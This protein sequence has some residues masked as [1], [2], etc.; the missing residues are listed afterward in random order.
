VKGAVMSTNIVSTA[1]HWN[2]I[3]TLVS[4]FIFLFE[5]VLPVRKAGLKN[6]SILGMK[7]I[8][9]PVLWSMSTLLGVIVGLLPEIVALSAHC[10]PGY[11]T[12]NW[13]H[14][15][16]YIILPVALF[17]LM[18]WVVYSQEKNPEITDPNMMMAVD[19]HPIRKSLVYWAGYAMA[20]PFVA[21]AMNVLL[22][23]R[24][25]LLN[26]ATFMSVLAASLCPLAIE[27]TQR[28]FAYI[29]AQEEIGGA[30][31]EQETSRVYE[32]A[33]LNRGKNLMIKVGV[34][35]LFHGLFITPNLTG[36]N[37]MIKVGVFF[38][39][40][41]IHSA[42]SDMD[43]LDSGHHAH[44][45][46]G[47]TSSLCHHQPHLPLHWLLQCLLH[48][49]HSLCDPGAATHL[50]SQEPDACESFLFGACSTCS[51]TEFFLRCQLQASNLKMA[52]T[53][54]PAAASSSGGR[55]WDMYPMDPITLET[56][57][58]FIFTF[59]VLGD[60]WGTASTDAVRSF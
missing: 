34:C 53:S 47:G 33:I 7:N 11:E 4:L 20:A 1:L 32:L 17:A 56:I 52:G 48:S 57:S 28:F 58:R 36:K 18:M 59:A 55:M 43:L 45:S 60:L 21:T 51:H 16:L 19:P 54:F 2:V 8:P 9:S 38:C 3:G 41:H 39:V 24:D 25:W 5:G 46:C 12:P 40:E 35:F 10:T 42:V 49:A 29:M 44:Y 50:A 27:M 31:Y 15:S 22:Q 13:L 30:E 23:R 37:L 14:A 6:V 26:M